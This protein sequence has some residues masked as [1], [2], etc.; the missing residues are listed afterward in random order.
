M[1]TKLPEI[2]ILRVKNSVEQALFVNYQLTIDMKKYCNTD[3]SSTYY[4]LIGVINHAG[5]QFV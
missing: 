2:L 5:S 1:I 3:S 4:S